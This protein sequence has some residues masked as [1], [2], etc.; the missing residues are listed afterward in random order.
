MLNLSIVLED[1]A[2]EA[3]DRAALVFGEL[4][5]PYSL[6]NTVANQ[7]ANLL[8]SRGIGKGDKVALA[9]PNLPYFPFVYY[10]IL[11]A[12]ATVVPLNVLLQSREITYHLE[13]SEAKA[14]FCFEGSPSCR[15]ASGAGRASRAPRGR[16][17]S[18]SCR[19]PRSPPSR[20]T[21]RP[22]GRRWTASPRSSRRCRPHPTTPR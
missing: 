3:P 20:S 10:G 2:R 11:K 12:G 8:V 13:D 1:S 21:A 6:V 4:R 15:W 22:S 17:T 9:C 14:L 5:V 19:P 16:S 7:V 18:S